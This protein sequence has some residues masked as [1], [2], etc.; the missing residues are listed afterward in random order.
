MKKLSALF[1]SLALLLS[2][3]SGL[4]EAPAV[5]PEDIQ[6]IATGPDIGIEVIDSS[7][8]RSAFP[9]TQDKVHVEDGVFHLESK[10][11]SLS[12]T[13]PFGMMAL[14]QDMAAQPEVYMQLQDGRK[15][16]QQLIDADINILFFDNAVGKEFWLMVEETKLSAFFPS[17]DDNF[18]LLMATLQKISGAQQTFSEVEINGKRF[19][20]LAEKVEDGRDYRLLYVIQDGKQITI[21]L[22]DESITPEM[23]ESHRIIAESIVFN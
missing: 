4:A 17:S 7:S 1:L 12:I 8:V 22:R 23:E 6:S 14:G 3:S 5:S 20:H 13:I 19:V 11:I 2:L 10:G 21:Q 18:D 9:E 16:A 15:T